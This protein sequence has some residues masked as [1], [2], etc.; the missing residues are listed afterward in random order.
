VHT[1]LTNLSPGFGTPGPG[2]LIDGGEE[3]EE[4][5]PEETD[6][7]AWRVHANVP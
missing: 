1:S 3:E 7:N 6:V 4:I 2:N 5:K